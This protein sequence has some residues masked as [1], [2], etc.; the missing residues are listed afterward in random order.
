MSIRTD[1]L[2]DLCLTPGPPGGEQPI[3]EIVMREIEGLVDDIQVDAM[4][5]IIAIKR[6]RDAQKV[7]VAA[8]MDEISF[9]ISHIDA[10]GFARFIPLGGFDPKTFTAQRVIV[11]G[12]EPLVG[13]MGSKPIHLMSPEERTK[14]PKEKDY[15][16]DFGMPRDRVKEIIAVGDKATRE[17][18]FIE[19]G[20]A[21]S[22]KSLDNRVSVFIL[23]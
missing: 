17:R 20:D 8:H 21:V 23:I 18:D 19:I 13:V 7:M 22:T 2:R 6:G 14:A 16:I 15:F 9:M 5:N 4:G 11:H 1:L 12:K 3:R 10:E